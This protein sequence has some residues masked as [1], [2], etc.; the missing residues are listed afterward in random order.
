MGEVMWQK[1]LY[2]VILFCSMSTYSQV[3]I[4]TT[5]P[6]SIL[7][8]RDPNPAVPTA[9]SGI[10]IPQVNVQPPVANREGQLVYNTATKSLLV[11][12]G[13]NWN[14]V[15]VQFHIRT[16]AS[17]TNIVLN[18]GD[19]VPTNGNH[20]VILNT[21]GFTATDYFVSGDPNLGLRVPVSGYYK[22]SA[23][24]YCSRDGDQFRVRY[25]VTSGATNTNY[26]F[27]VSTNTS[28]NGQRYNSF[29]KTLHLNAGDQVIL[30]IHGSPAGTRCRRGE[31]RTELHLELV[32]LD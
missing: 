24:Y 11:Y 22:V 3:G 10:A 14:P 12:N 23:S 2:I 20:E 13:A 30:Q 1:L 6:Q 5:N 16:W 27:A 29:P 8:I 32:K 15:P 7:D 26:N 21:N 9:A 25:R 28:V 19:T 31:N 17:G 18:T 4:G